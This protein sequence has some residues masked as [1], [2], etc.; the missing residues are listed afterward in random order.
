[1]DGTFV[2][3]VDDFGGRSARMVP[4]G[5]RRVEIVAPGFET[6]TVDVRIPEN[7]TVTFTRD[8]EPAVARPAAAT[9]VAIPHKA[10]YVV[11]QCYIGD[12]MPRPGDMPAGCRVE[13]VRVIP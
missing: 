4:A 6:L 13:D 12:R 8:L 11:P 9:P 5:P 3:T 1:M 10:L 7:D 2:G